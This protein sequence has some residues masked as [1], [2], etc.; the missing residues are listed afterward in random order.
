MFGSISWELS[1]EHTD[2]YVQSIELYITSNMTGMGN[3]IWE[4]IGDDNR[5]K[6]TPGSTWKTGELSGSKHIALTA[7][8]SDR[9]K[10][11]SNQS[12]Q[13]LPAVRSN[14][15]EGTTL[16]MEVKLQGET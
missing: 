7:I 5:V 2:L 3:I 13:L 14:A 11:S 9:K 12:T 1:L 15:D 10:L 6:P 8:M 16:R 4:L